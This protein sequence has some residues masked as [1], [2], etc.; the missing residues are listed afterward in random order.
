MRWLFIRHDREA[1]ASRPRARRHRIWDWTQ[2]YCWCSQAAAAQSISLLWGD[3]WCSKWRSLGSQLRCRDGIRLNPVCKCVC[4]TEI[5]Y[6]R[7]VSHSV[8]HRLVVLSV[9]LMSGPCWAAYWCVVYLFIYL[10]SYFK[11]AHGSICRV[12][13]PT[14][15][16]VHSLCDASSWKLTDSSKEGK[17]TDVGNLHWTCCDVS[18]FSQAKK[19]KGIVKQFSR[20]F[21]SHFK[22]CSGKGEGGVP[23]FTAYERTF[24]PRLRK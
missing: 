1:D 19:K 11:P 21:R 20:S 6:G 13:L 17:V 3:K 16:C 7:L 10:F 18:L 15:V 12:L 8:Y 4:V 14:V 23:L 22:L 9:S 2:E 24:H 5:G